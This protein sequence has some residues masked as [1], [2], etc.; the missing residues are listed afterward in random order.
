[1][2]WCL[3]CVVTCFTIVPTFY[4]TENLILQFNSGERPDLVLGVTVIL[5]RSHWCRILGRS[6]PERAGG[7][8]YLLFAGRKLDDETL[9]PAPAL[10]D[11][12][13]WRETIHWTGA[14]TPGHREAG[15][16]L[17][18]CDLSQWLRGRGTW[19]ISGTHWHTSGPRREASDHYQQ[20]VINI[21]FRA[22]TSVPGD[23]H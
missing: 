7:Q 23:E 10:A 9:A 17:L 20:I 13:V 5:Y 2:I 21:L 19:I 22:T 18:R 12:S 4:E 8:R 11:E 6:E 1:M 15:S 14:G 3:G 16:S